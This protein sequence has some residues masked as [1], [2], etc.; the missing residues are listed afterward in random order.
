MREGLSEPETT[1]SEIIQKIGRSDVK[2]MIPQV[3]TLC[4][5][6]LLHPASTATAERVFSRLRTLKTYLRSTMSQRRLN[7]MLILSIYKDK[8]DA[9]D[10]VSLINEFIG[11]GDSKRRNAFA[12]L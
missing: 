11:A 3:V 6:Y 5:L 7:T 8:L 12:T 9:L 2:Q 4:K 10:E 1:I